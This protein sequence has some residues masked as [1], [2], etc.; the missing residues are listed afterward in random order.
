MWVTVYKM[1]F[2]LYSSPGILPSSYLL[3]ANLNE[4]IAA[5]NSKRNVALTKKIQENEC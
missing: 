3:I 1:A 2:T 4:V 5:N